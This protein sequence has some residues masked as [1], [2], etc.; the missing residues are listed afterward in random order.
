MSSTLERF[1]LLMRQ[2]N[3]GQQ[4]VRIQK[5]ERALTSYPAKVRNK[6]GA[7]INILKKNFFKTFLRSIESSL[8]VF[9][10]FT[11]YIETQPQC[12]ILNN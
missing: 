11:I 8:C 9:G 10:L 2:P 7:S 12:P 1:T 6:I 4:E 3:H 5:P